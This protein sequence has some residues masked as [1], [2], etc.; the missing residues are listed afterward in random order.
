MFL[1]GKNDVEIYLPTDLSTH[2]GDK[3]N[4]NAGFAPA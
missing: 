1:R 3:Q 2:F 4:V